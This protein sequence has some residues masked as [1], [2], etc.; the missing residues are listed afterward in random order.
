MIS[1]RMYSFLKLYCTFA[2]RT[3]VVPITWC[4]QNKVLIPSK[5][6]AKIAFLGSIYFN[7]FIIFLFC[8]LARFYTAEDVETFNTVMSYT[9]ATSIGW[10][11]HSI[12]ILQEKSARATFNA[13]LFY[14]KHINSKVF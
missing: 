2:S 7:L 11:A 13:V 12:L 4:P 8:Q 6:A 14:L 3:G 9:F 10:I 1:N 5:S